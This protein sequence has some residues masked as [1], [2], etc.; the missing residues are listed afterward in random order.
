MELTGPEQA[1]V[2]GSYEHGNVPSGFIKGRESLDSLSI[3]S[4]F[5]ELC[6]T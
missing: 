3:P 6:S 1:M 2:E 4:A 5:Q